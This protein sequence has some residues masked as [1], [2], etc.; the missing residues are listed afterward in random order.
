MTLAR[1]RSR[2]A[3]VVL[4]AAV[5]PYTVARVRSGD[6]TAPVGTRRPSSTIPQ[7]VM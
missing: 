6:G 3:E 4:T 7:V 2:T 5:G 1:A